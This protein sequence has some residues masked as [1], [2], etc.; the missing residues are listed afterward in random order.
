MTFRTLPLATGGGSAGPTADAPPRAI[1]R[2]RFGDPFTFAVSEG[3]PLAAGQ[4]Q[5]TTKN[6]SFF[7]V[8]PTGPSIP[9][10]VGSMD[11]Q[12]AANYTPSGLMKVGAF[13]IQAAGWGNWAPTADG[14]GTG[15][16]TAED[17]I[18]YG[19]P[20]VASWSWK[21]APA[22]A[23]TVNA[24]RVTERWY[25]VPG[26]PNALYCEIELRPDREGTLAADQTPGTGPIAVAHMIE[27]LAERAGTVAYDSALDGI[28]ILSKGPS[29]RVLSWFFLRTLGNP[30]SGHYF[31]QNAT[32]DAQQ[33]F[34]TGAL[35]TGTDNLAP[36]A[37]A[38]Y[39][40]Y[41]AV[42]ADARQQYNPTFRFVL[43]VGSTELQAKNATRSVPNVSSVEA[44]LKHL[45]KIARFPGLPSGSGRDAKAVDLCQATMVQ[46][47][48]TESDFHPENY[49][50]DGTP[51]RIIW[52]GVGKWQAA[53][54]GDNPIEAHAMVAF[55]PDLS[56][57]QLDYMLNVVM[58]QTT[59]YLRGDPKNPQY[60]QHCAAYI[61]RAVARYLAATGDTATCLTFYNKVKLM[62]SYWTSTS[63]A[64]Y[65]HPNWPT[66]RLLSASHQNE[67]QEVGPT[68]TSSN[69]PSGD[70]WATGTHYDLCV[71]M[72]QIATT[73]GITADIAGWNSDAAAFK[74]SLRTYCW[75]P[76]QNWF[77]ATMMPTSPSGGQPDA[78]GRFQAVRTFRAYY[79][80]YSGYASPAQAQAIRDLAMDPAHMR[81]AYGMRTADKVW[82]GYLPGDWMMGGCRPYNDA[83]L[84][85]GLR[86]YGFT[87]DADAVLD[88]MVS[89]MLSLGSTPE[90]VNA[91]TGAPG[92]TRYF[93]W[94]AGMLLEALLAKNAPDLLYG[95]GTSQITS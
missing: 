93:T 89:V 17:S 24:L 66:V 94:A 33:Y 26:V 55:D 5:K 70:D 79:S 22:A 18:R 1:G 3:L 84:S 69:F 73:L 83:A 15:A 7:F 32:P 88:T 87:A 31:E 45:S 58:D 85:V 57:D 75:D 28:S 34:A 71:H 38:A 41:L 9:S 6:N 23:T 50:Y 86:R 10:V 51:R 60:L 16:I 13:A 37:N 20:G 42:A 64:V 63:P 72:A 8:A 80:L 12:S 59:G 54:S 40:G 19:E 67:I 27:A 91:D 77:Q 68:T 4:V 56:R 36:T 74:A 29:T 47:I 95:V 30:S 39:R 44:R 35:P 2:M 43:G 49:A 46:N 62:Y 78:L 82:S 11:T 65:R 48:R 14:D 81:G 92:Q 21:L 76:T 25:A 90:L 61:G 52:G 53:W